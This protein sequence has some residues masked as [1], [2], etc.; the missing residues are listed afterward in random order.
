MSDFASQSRR[1]LSMDD[2]LLNHLHNLFNQIIIFFEGSEGSLGSGVDRR[3]GCLGNCKLLLFGKYWQNKLEQCSLQESSV[4][5]CLK[6]RFLHRFS[7]NFQKL[8]IKSIFVYMN[9]VHGMSRVEDSRDRWACPI[10][11]SKW[12]LRKRN[13][14]KDCTCNIW[15]TLLEKPSPKS[16]K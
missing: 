10:W 6:I 4:H 2:H 16:S 13:P 7:E 12:S 8:L 5:F 14:A 3:L 15:R 9:K 1:V 11:R